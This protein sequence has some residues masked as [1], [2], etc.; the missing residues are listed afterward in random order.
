MLKRLLLTRRFRF[1]VGAALFTAVALSAATLTP[2]PA[3]SGVGPNRCGTEIWYWSDAS[4]TVFV[5]MQGWKPAECGCFYYS[6]GTL[7]VYR[8]FEDSFCAGAQ[9]GGDGESQAAYCRR[10]ST[11]SV[12]AAR[13]AG[14]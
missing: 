4:H 14:A 7:S 10:V 3:P 13:R 9:R 1:L 11:G 6:S 12:A 2:A 5:G 8:T